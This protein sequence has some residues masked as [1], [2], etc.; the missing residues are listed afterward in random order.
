M[1]DV[2]M[3]VVGGWVGGWLVKFLTICNTLRKTFHN[4]FRHCLIAYIHFYVTCILMKY[5][6]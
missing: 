6:S 4:G 2:M 5:V 1:N 3:F